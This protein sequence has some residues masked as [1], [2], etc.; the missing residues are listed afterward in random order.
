VIL[1]EKPH[2]QYNTIAL[3]LSQTSLTCG[4]F[5]RS[6]KIE[7]LMAAMDFPLVI[8]PARRYDGNDVRNF[9]ESL[10]LMRRMI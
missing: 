8:G 4:S 10:A 3:P 7:P 9:M 5:G 6:T 1:E 2:C